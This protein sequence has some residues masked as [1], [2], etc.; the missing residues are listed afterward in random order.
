MDVV[1]E[2]MDVLGVLGVLVVGNS[3]S[4]EREKGNVLEKHGEEGDGWCPKESRAN[5][6][7]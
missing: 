3:K 1:L 4:G 7:L 6:Y 2:L 5:R